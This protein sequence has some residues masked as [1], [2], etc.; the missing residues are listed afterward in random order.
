MHQADLLR[1]ITLGELPS[2]WRSLKDFE[3]EIPRRGQKTAWGG[4]GRVLEAPNLGESL[5]GTHTGCSPYG[6][7]GSKLQYKLAEGIKTE[8]RGPLKQS[9]IG[10]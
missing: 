8:R 3:P 9:K 10:L 2:R 6:K 4:G 5:Q 1:D 7:R